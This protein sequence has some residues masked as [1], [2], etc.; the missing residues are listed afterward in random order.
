MQF[1]L[2]K[3]WPTLLLMG[4]NI[5]DAFSDQITAFLVGHP[6]VALVL[7]GCITLAANVTKGIKKE[8]TP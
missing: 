2:M 3:L 1:D 4:T 6:K 7:A 5:V 8:P